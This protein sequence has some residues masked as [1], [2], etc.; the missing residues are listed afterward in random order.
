MYLEKQQQGLPPSQPT[1][2]QQRTQ[3]TVHQQRTQPTVHQQRTQPTVHQQSQLPTQPAAVAFPSIGWQSG[4]AYMLENGFHV[5][6]SFIYD[7]LVERITEHKSTNNFLALKT[8]YTLFVSG[9]VQSVQM[10]QNSCY[11]YYKSTCN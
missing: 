6:R 11:V 7:Y 9:H 8:G 10:N 3:P 5:T 4:I 2:H 1:V